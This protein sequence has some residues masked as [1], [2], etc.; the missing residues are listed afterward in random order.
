MCNNRVRVVSGIKYSSSARISII[1]YK[2]AT[3]VLYVT[4]YITS[5][6]NMVLHIFRSV[7]L[8]DPH[9]GSLYAFGAVSEGL[10]VVEGLY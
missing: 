10:K 1:W 9:D 8:P 5:T 4:Y 2:T 6:N 7:F 3:H